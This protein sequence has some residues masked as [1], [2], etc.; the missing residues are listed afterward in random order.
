MEFLDENISQDYE[1]P[2]CMV[3]LKDPQMVS[4]CGRKFCRSCIDRIVDANKPCPY[5][6]EEFTCMAEKQLNRR[7]LDLKIKCAR[8]K[9][10]CE[11]TGELRLLDSHLQNVCL[12]AEVVCRLGCGAVM[13]RE[14]LEHHEVDYCAKRSPESKL[15]R[16]TQRL[17]TRLQSVEKICEE[18]TTKI[19]HLEE[20]VIRLTEC[21]EAKS[22]EIASLNQSIQSMKDN[23]QVDMTQSLKAIQGELIKR[24]FCLSFSLN[25][26]ECDWVGPPFLSHQNGYLLQLSA[27]MS[28][29]Q[30]SLSKFMR[31]VILSGARPDKYP[32][33]L[34]VDILPR[35]NDEASLDWP[36]YI[37]VDVLVLTNSDS[38]AN[39]KLVTLSCYKG[40]PPSSSAAAPTRSPDYED[41]DDD[42][43][44]NEYV[45]AHASHSF[46][47]CLVI[48]NIKLSLEPLTSQK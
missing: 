5:C 11:W 8:A 23:H 24:C 34:A 39:G 1:C 41:D 12:F 7:I 13:L 22:L 27:S 3:V 44:D 25:L 37:S 19:T 26:E 32:I 43:D 14:A 2:I 28:K 29:H 17:E 10:G 47:C 38:D 21:N 36:I 4:C 31:S 48:L 30:S 6:K 15:L 35:Q 20:E 33:M 9:V 42:D 45:I 40:S 16:L 18:Q 46:T